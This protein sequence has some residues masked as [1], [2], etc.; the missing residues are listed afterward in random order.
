MSLNGASVQKLEKYN[1]FVVGADAVSKV[2]FAN[3]DK[4]YVVVGN[5]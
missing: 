5:E 2:I 3:D 4:F 1:E